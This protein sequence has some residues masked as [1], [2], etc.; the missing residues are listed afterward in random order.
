MQRP[1]RCSQRRSSA[2][3][4]LV[5]TTR[6]RSQDAGGADQQDGSGSGAAEAAPSGDGGARPRRRLTRAADATHSSPIDLALSP[7]PDQPTSARRRR[8]RRGCVPEWHESMHGNPMVFPLQITYCRYDVEE[9]GLVCGELA[10]VRTVLRRNG[11]LVGSRR[12]PTEAGTVADMLD[13]LE[14]RANNRS[15]AE[16]PST[17]HRSALASCFKSISHHSMCSAPLY[18]EKCASCQLSCSLSPYPASTATRLGLVEAFLLPPA[19]EWKTCGGT[20]M[21]S[22]RG[23]SILT[24]PLDPAREGGARLRT[25]LQCVPRRQHGG[26]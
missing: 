19:G 21:P 15:A 9:A 26:P 14:A 22:G 7:S 5:A 12:G 24:H 13:I 25:T 16:L 17:A 20:G 23:R 10:Q 1:A 2:A 11:G 4:R 8:L 3:E 6:S 18:L